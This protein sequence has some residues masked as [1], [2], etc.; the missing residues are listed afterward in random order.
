VLDQLGELLGGTTGPRGGRRSDSV[1]EAMVKSGARSV[2]TQ[3]GHEIVRGVLGS[4]F[5]NGGRSRR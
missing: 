1:L 3:L 4:L 5:G 2:G